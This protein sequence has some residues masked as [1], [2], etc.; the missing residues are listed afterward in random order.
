MLPYESCNLGSINLAQMVKGEKKKE[1]DWDKLGQTVD[2]A[3]HFLDN[4]I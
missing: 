1:I 4:V 3:V 2:T